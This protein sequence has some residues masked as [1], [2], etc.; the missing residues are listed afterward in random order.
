[1]VWKIASSDFQIKVWRHRNRFHRIF[2]V[3]FIPKLDHFFLDNVAEREDIVIAQGK[4][5]R[6]ICFQQV[7]TAAETTGCDVRTRSNMTQWQHNFGRVQLWEAIF[8]NLLSIYI[9]EIQDTF[10]FPFNDYSLYEPKFQ[11]F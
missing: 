4:I 11:I 10:Y 1:M 5:S 8:I 2:F 7:T 9:L 6:C 3:F